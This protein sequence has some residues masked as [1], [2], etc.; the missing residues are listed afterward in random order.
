MKDDS[1]NFDHKIAMLQKQIEVRTLSL[2]KQFKKKALDLEKK[3]CQV[4]D[5]HAATVEQL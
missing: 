3:V 2:E 1:A 5:L 4:K